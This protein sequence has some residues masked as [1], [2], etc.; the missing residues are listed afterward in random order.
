MFLG[1]GLLT[2]SVT[3]GGGVRPRYSQEQE[4][5]E[6]VEKLRWKMKMNFLTVGMGTVAQWSRKEESS[7]KRVQN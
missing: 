6:T 5:I 1:G 2:K 3:W 7:R 4:G